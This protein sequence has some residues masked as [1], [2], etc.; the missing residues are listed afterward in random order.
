MAAAVNLNA[1]EAEQ[2][3]TNL[4]KFSLDQ[5]GSLKW[6]NQ[7]ESLETLNIQVSHLRLAYLLSKYNRLTRIAWL[8]M[9]SLCLR[10]S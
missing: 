8:K 10:L 2:I 7:H 6:F 9:K 4:K 1:F 5:V 3:V